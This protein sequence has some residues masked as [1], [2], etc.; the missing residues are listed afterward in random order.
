[1]ASRRAQRL[2]DQGA[3][4][5][6]TV[7]VTRPRNDGKGDVSTTPLPTKHKRRR[8]ITE[9]ADDSRIEMDVDD[10]RS[11]S[12]SPSPV[13]PSR[14]PWQL[15]PPPETRPDAD[16][17]LTRPWLPPVSPYG[18]IEE[19]HAIFSDPFKLL[20]VCQL[21]NK[22]TATVV[23]HLL[24]AL[25]SCVRMNTGS[26]AHSVSHPRVALV[27]PPGTAK[28]FSRRIRALMCWQRRTK[29]CWRA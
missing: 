19:D 14:R 2:H 9:D 29:T 12:F 23:R 27:R 16:G 4:G 25:V 18:L 7:G 10:V 20:V 28:G 5:D 17:N 21:L 1:M 15:R 22:T 26:L 8:V 13:S 24:Y 6:C 11:P 3:T